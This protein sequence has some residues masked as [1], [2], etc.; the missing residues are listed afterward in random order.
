MSESLSSMSKELAPEQ[1]RRFGPDRLIVLVKSI[2]FQAKDINSYE[3]VDPV[4]SDLPPFSPGSHIDLHFRDR[5]VRQYSLCGDPSDRKRYL[6]AVQRERNGRGGSQAIFEKVTVG[7]RL[8]ISAPRN[9]FPVE[10]RARRHVLLAGGIGI[11][12]LLA[13]ARSFAR[14]GASFSLWYCV[15]S[16]ERIAFQSELHQLQGSGEV[17]IHCDDESTSPKLDVH[18][19]LRPAPFGTHLYYCGPPG[20]MKAVANASAHWPRDAVHCEH[21]NQSA[22]SPAHAKLEDRT[23]ILADTTIDVGFSVRLS[24]SDRS[25]NVPPDKSIV[26]VLREHDIEVPTSCESGLCGTCKTRYLSGTPIHRD[27]ILDDEQKKEF[28]M[29][30]CSGASSK[31]LVLDM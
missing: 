7:R 17:H 13:M 28:I 3:V 22:T 26:Q 12:P 5:R 11:T 30:C 19:L 24:R 25:F 4:G 31:E 15:R 16:A 14:S 18:A 23:D 8:T 9:H 21:F 29:L 6:F 1:L 2:T 27:Y 10:T 20:F